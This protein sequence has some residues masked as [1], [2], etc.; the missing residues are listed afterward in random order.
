MTDSCVIRRTTHS[1]LVM[2]VCLYLPT[3]ICSLNLNSINNK[4]GQAWWPKFSIVKRNSLVYPQ[5]VPGHPR[6]H[7]KTLYQKVLELGWEIHNL[8]HCQMLIN[9]MIQRQGGTN[10]NILR[11]IMES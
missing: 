8:T 10:I 6:R 2:F 5:R 9:F 1:I 4:Y 3:Q 11:L 7:T